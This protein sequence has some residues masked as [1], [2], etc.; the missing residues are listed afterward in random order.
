M[1]YRFHRQQQKN[2]NRMVV[3]K[4]VSYD[5]VVICATCKVK[6][7][8]RSQG[9]VEALTIYLTCLV[10]LLETRMTNSGSF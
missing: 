9:G 1:I 10:C 2:Q 7:Q 8:A 4:T 6:Y 5:C 3:R